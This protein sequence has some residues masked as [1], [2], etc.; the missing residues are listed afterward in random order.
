MLVA[1]IYVLIAA[2]ETAAGEGV[3]GGE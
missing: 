3:W 2:G 1:M